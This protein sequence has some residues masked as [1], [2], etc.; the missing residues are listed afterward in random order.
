MILFR[1]YENM[2]LQ[3]V[4]GSGGNKRKLIEEEFH[5]LY[6]SSNIIRIIGARGSVVVRHYATSRKV[7][8]SRPDE[9][10]FF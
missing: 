6:F 8:R 2:M 5:N 9:V 1:V 10:D 4:F 7:A 3:K